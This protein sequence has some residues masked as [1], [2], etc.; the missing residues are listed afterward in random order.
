MPRSRTRDDQKKKKKKKG[1]R[2]PFARFRPNPRPGIRLPAAPVN[3]PPIQGEVPPSGF[4]G[5]RQE[6]IAVPADAQGNHVGDARP[7][8][9]P[10]AYAVT[11]L[12]QKPGYSLFGEREYRFGA[13][14]GDS[15]VFL[16]PRREVRLAVTHDGGNA[17]IVGIPNERGALAALITRIQAN[18]FP[19]AK[20][21]AFRLA[22]PALSLWSTILDVPVEVA[23]V[24]LVEE[25][26]TTIQMSVTNPYS[27]TPL[28]LAHNRASANLRIFLSY[29]REALSS[30]SEP[31]QILCLFKVI[32]GIRALRLREERRGGGELIQPPE[33]RVPDTE[34]DQMA[35]LQRL[36]P[37]RTSPWDA[38]DLHSVFLPE[39]VGQ[40]VEDLVRSGGRRQQP[41][42]LCALRNEIAHTIGPAG[43]GTLLI[44][45]ETLHTDRVSN[46]LPL[47]R[48]LARLLLLNQFP[49]ELW[50]PRADAPNEARP[51]IEALRGVE[52]NPP[53]HVDEN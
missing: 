37:F 3:R 25:A 26:T 5:Q 36:F 12:L 6:V 50:Q 17:E 39:A 44:A 10:G 53:E 32:E 11:F 42:A 2:G 29:Y 31:Y 1:S 52:E 40:L 27:D 19:S 45:D 23:R 33:E 46:W 14:I 34:Q 22:A 48:C 16:G 43:A 20:Q 7:E 9:N 18:D 49:N 51:A 41:G 38:F 30:N 21:A 28:A 24:E 8:G 47:T 13:K 15:H 35:W 4:G